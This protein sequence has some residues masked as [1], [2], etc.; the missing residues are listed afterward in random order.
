MFSFRHFSSPDT[1]SNSTEE[2]T[3][4]SLGLIIYVEAVL[5]AIL[6]LSFLSN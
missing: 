2:N 6:S 1:D 4:G 5:L 3:S